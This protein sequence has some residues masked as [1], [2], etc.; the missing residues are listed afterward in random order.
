M[1]CYGCESTKSWDDCVEKEGACADGFDRCAKVYAEVKKNGT[2]VETYIRGCLPEAW[3]NNNDLISFC[4]ES[5]KC[6]VY[7][8][9]GDLCN[10]AAVHMVSAIILI[11]SALVAAFIQ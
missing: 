8:C 11:P 9:T 1:K 6:K 7:C 4:K 2:S 5:S 10:G 3:C